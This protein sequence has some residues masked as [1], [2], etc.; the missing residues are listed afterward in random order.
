M[1]DPFR[2]LGVVPGATR[3][4]IRA[5]FRRLVVRYHPDKNPGREAST[6]RRFCEVVEAYE[7]LCDDDRRRAFETRA[8]RA[9]ATRPAP[10][11]RPYYFDLD[12][13]QSVA[14]QVLYLLLHRRADEADA[15]LAREE[16]RLG[17]RFLRDHLER[18]DLV[19]CLF[20]LAEVREGAGALEAA[21]SLY[22]EVLGLETK[23]HRSRHFFPEVVARLKALYTSRIPRTVGPE[24]ALRFYQ[25]AEALGAGR[26]ERGELAKRRAVA[27]FELGEIGRAAECLREAYRLNPRLKGAK[28]ITEKI[29][30]AEGVCGR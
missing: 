21:A 20:L 6:G 29:R 12:D 26:V 23:V 11:R 19:D 4:E 22:E 10:P 28:K 14:R 8:R 18:E 27:L 9:A 5:A 1:L 16:S 3:D 7:I 30:A 15:I 13:P 17:P 2:I 25:R 24:E